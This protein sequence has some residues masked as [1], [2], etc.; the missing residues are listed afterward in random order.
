MP[1]PADLMVSCL[2]VTLA[3]PNRLPHLKRSIACYAQQTHRNKELVI[4]ADAGDPGTKAAIAAHVSSL[5]RDDISIVDV[6][7]TLSVGALRNISMASARG[8]VVC[9]WDDDDLCH[10]QRIEQQL[11]ALLGSGSQGVCLEET[12]LFFTDSRTLYCTNW[13][14]TPVRS[15]PGTLMC[16]T[17]APIRYHETGPGC[18]HG[19]DTVVALELQR[20]G[21]L[22]ALADVPH[23]YVY[24]CHGANSWAS[25]HHRM[26][27]DRLAI[28]RGLLSRREASLRGGLA[29]YDFGTGTVTVQ[30]GNGPA[31]VLGVDAAPEPRMADT[32]GHERG[33]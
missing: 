3:V 33:G 24:V 23:L 14:A 28:S 27:V 12:M 31:F 5:G 15:V 20:L 18:R 8:P 17:S 4:V 22:H 7:G 6:P 10:P 25:D 32:R 21:G 29:P 13:H 9:Q 26:L 2:M 19:E 11:L 30:G 16:W 1:K